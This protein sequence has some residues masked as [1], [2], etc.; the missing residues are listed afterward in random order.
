MISKKTV[1]VAGDGKEFDNEKLAIAYEGRD[2][3][4]ETYAK[5]LENVDMLLDYLGRGSCHYDHHGYCQEHGL[6]DRP[7]PVEVLT[8]LLGS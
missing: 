5:V 3:T 2:K 7:C 4:P 6:H 1:Y 8:E